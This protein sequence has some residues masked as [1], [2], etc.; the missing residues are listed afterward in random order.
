[1]ARRRA[2]LNSTIGKSYRLHNTWV[3]RQI[4]SPNMEAKIGHLGPEIYVRRRWETNS[5]TSRLQ[6]PSAKPQGITNSQAPSTT[7]GGFTSML[8]DWSFP[9]AW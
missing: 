4:G 2:I 3:I 9:G 5:H 7:G 1:M 8:G 6:T